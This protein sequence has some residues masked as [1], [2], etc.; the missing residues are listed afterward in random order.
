MPGAWGRGAGLGWG[1][2]LPSF[3]TGT[4]IPGQQG[5]GSRTLPAGRPVAQ[6]LV[7]LGLQEAGE[8]GGQLHRH[9][10]GRKSLDLDEMGHFASRPQRTKQEECQRDTWELPKWGELGSGPS[11]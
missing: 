11:V 10:K 4:Q 6:G 5:R 8:G 3:F 9:G 2:R 1:G 7:G